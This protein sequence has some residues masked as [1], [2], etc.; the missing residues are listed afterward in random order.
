M[1]SWRSGHRRSATA[2]HNQGMEIYQRTPRQQWQEQAAPLLGRETDTEIARKLGVTPRQ[3]GYL[4]SKLNKKA[5]CAAR[6]DLATLKK[7]G[8]VPDAELAQELGI[9][10]SAV[11]KKRRAYERPCARRGMPNEALQ[12][13]GKLTDMEVALKYGRTYDT[14]RAWRVKAGLPPVVVVRRWTAQEVAKLGT[15]PDSLLARELARRVRSVRAK[16]EHLGIP[17]YTA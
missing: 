14:A 7:L 6:W 2:R 15:M 13:L 11:K 9:S 10:V 12:D 3:V 16:R 1:P 8:A 5:R 17:Q 4:R